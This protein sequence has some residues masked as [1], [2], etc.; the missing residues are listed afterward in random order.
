MSGQKVASMAPWKYEEQMSFLKAHLSQKRLQAS[1]S[2]IMGS[3][4]EIFD[5]GASDKW[6]SEDIVTQDLEETHPG[7]RYSA[8]TLPDAP[9]TTPSSKKR[10][11]I[12]TNSAF[13]MLSTYLASKNSDT[14]H[15]TAYFKM[16]ESTVRTFP[17]VQQVEIKARIS[18]ML[19]EYEYKNLNSA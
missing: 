16:V 17:P 14:D 6:E 5:A 12:L 4:D 11:C 15:L 13:D 19:T 2:D 18:S 10:K 3:Q 7:E 9:K 1:N 8:I